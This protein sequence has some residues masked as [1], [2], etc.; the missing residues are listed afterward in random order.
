MALPFSLACD[1]VFYS[2]MNE[3]MNSNQILLIDDDEELCEAVSTYL[4]RHG[5]Q[6]KTAL[7]PSIAYKLILKNQPDLILLDVMLPEQDGFEVC[8][9]LVAETNIFGIIPIIILT[10][11]GDVF[12]RI[13]GLE[14]G[15]SD[16]LPKPFEPREL[17]ARIRSTLR[18]TTLATKN[19]HKQLKNT[20][21]SK[22]LYLN[23]QTQQVW[24]DGG[25]LELTAMEYALLALFYKQPNSIISRDQIMDHLRG[26]DACIYSRAIDALV[27]RLRKKLGD[28][29]QN[30][31]FIKTVWGRGYEFIGHV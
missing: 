18:Q 2:L 25:L 22:G 30:P 6:V 7:A 9:K 12:D 1:S 17:L 5:Y 19:Q 20:P 31:R 13:V 21:P 23:Q 29:R 10:A 27:K 24:L 4:G 11:R 8:K 3:N 28:E 16:Y 14:M 26:T 15:A